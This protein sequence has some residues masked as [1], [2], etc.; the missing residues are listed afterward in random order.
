MSDISLWENRKKKK[1]IY[2][3]S[4]QAKFSATTAFTWK[5]GVLFLHSSGD[6]R[7]RQV[8]WAQLPPPQKGNLILFQ[9]SF[10]NCMKLYTGWN[11]KCPAAFKHMLPSLQW[12]GIASPFFF[13]TLK[14]HLC[15]WIEKGVWSCTVLLLR[16]PY[17]LLKVFYR[18]AASEVL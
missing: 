8:P 3:W 2:V 17:V 11:V 10:T 9:P 16:N 7:P 14:F 4:K 5:K 12:I 13:L 18:N 15:H 1:K 6:W